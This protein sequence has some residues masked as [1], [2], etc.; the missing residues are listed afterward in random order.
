MSTKSDTIVPPCATDANVQLDNRLRDAWN[1]NLK[2]YKAIK[3]SL[4]S[5]VLIAFGWFLVL[6]GADPTLVFSGTL[7]VVALLNGIEFA[8]FVD[9]W[10]EVR[11]AQ[12]RDDED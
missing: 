5:L 3:N 1:M 10:S 7:A 4:L 11:Q 12:L 6:E 8:E 9:A 2:T